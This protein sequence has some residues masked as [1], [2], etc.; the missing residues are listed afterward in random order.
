MI[1]I[2]VLADLNGI[3]GGN[4]NPTGNAISHLQ[5]LATVALLGG[6][7]YVGCRGR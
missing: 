7:G 2:A 5:D 6:A 1:G 3:P 4:I